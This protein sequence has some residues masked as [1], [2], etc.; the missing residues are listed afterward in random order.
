MGKLYST[1]GLSTIIAVVLIL[2][3]LLTGA[4]GAYW[5]YA[6]QH[7]KV[8]DLTVKT[9][10]LNSQV[11]SLDKQVAGLTDQLNEACRSTQP[12]GNSCEAYT[13]TSAKGVTIRIFSPA[14]N[15]TVG[16]PIAVI[17]EV[18]GNWSFEAQFPV[19]LVDS[20]GTVVASSMAHV[21]GNWQTSELVPFSAQLIFASSV[22]GT[23]QIVLE[24]DNPSGLPAN[25]DTLA[26]SVKF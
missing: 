1:S 16:S 13:Y 26:V 19:R 10:T 23:G 15:A 4:G 3:A 11:S 14:M 18:P 12:P 6:W 20:K 21:L 24:K 22:S 2:L 25:S 5:V 17:G 9:D 8:R 7:N